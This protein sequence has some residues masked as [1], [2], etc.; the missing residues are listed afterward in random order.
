MAKRHL[1]PNHPASG[2]SHTR[3]REE[4]WRSAAPTIKLSTALNEAVRLQSAPGV[5]PA[6]LATSLSTL[7]DAHY[8]AGH[9][10]VCRSLYTRA[11]EMHRQ[12]YDPKHPLIAR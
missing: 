2:E 5:A 9:Y 11:L 1:P 7:A 8:S 12:I 10:D 6:D 4:C 3:L